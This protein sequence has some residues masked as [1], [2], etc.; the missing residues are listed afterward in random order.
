LANDFSTGL[1]IGLLFLPLY[2]VLKCFK[3]S[4]GIKVIKVLF[5]IIAIIQLSLVGYSLTAHVNLG[6]DL[7]G[8]NLQDIIHTLK[9]SVNISFLAVLPFVIIPFAY[10]GIN[11]LL[12]LF[13]NKINGKHV[14]IILLIFGNISWFLANGSRP[15]NQN[16]LHFLVADIVREQNDKKMLSNETAASFK[17]E[18]PLEKPGS[19]TKDVLSPF[20]NLKNEKPNIVIIMVEGLGSDFV[21]NGEYKGFTPF[22]DGLISKSLYWENFLS[23]A[24]R[25]FG[26]APSLLASLPFGEKGLMEMEKLPKHNSL[27]RILKSNGY[28]TSYFCGDELNFDRKKNFLE[29]NEIDH[30]I[31]VNRYGPEYVETQKTAAGFSWGYPDHEIFKKTLTEMNNFKQPRLDVIM[32]LTNHEPF[33]FPEKNDYLKKVDQILN[34]KFQSEKDKYSEYKKIFAA[35]SYT[36]NSIKYFM[37]AYSKRPEY[38]N[39][40]FIITGDHR[41]IPIPQK[42]NLSRFH[43][44]L[45]IY[46]PMLKKAVKFKSVSS[47]KDITPSLVAFLSNKFDFKK[48][49]KTSWL[50]QGLDTVRKFRNTEN[51]AFMRYKGGLLDY[52]HNNYFYSDNTLFKVDENFN[53]TE[54]SDGDQL[55]QITTSFSDFKRLN[56]YL[57][58]KDKITKSKFDKGTTEVE[59]K[60]TSDEAA[61]INKTV[62]GLGP[63]HVFLLARELAFHEEHKKARLLCAYILNLVPNDGD[64]RTLRGRTFT[65]DKDYKAAE[66]EFLKVIN[67]TPFYSDSYSAIMDLYFWYDQNAKGVKIGEKALANKIDNKDVIF[68]LAQAYNRTNN[69]TQSKKIID[70]LLKVYPDNQD[71]LSFKKTLK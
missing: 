31:D 11:Y 14:I 26:V 2:L 38:S 30:L 15:V 25:T 34:T 10:Y 66:K 57:T 44:P 55:D 71:Y 40:I 69:T 52:M 60:F 28:T 33:D 65:W 35:L 67:D 47:H 20:F 19:E 70:R 18:Y 58:L 45:Y 9:T 5:V 24:G 23:N 16:K 13:S 42:D 12:N 6:A 21:G 17:S 4:L 61:Y 8:Y 7:I 49:D 41:L 37:D 1:I 51:I 62:K 56:A 68:K 3:E 29:S 59:F 39:T 43:V 54:V 36:D 48:L 50:G 53:L 32:T 63:D 27:I 46:S 22:L 64:V